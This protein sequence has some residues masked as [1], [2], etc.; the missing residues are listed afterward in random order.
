MHVSQ[1]LLGSLVR[2]GFTLASVI[3]K[4]D[5]LPTG[6]SRDE[7]LT[8][9]IAKDELSMKVRIHMVHQ[10][11]D[12]FHDL[13]MK[14]ATPG[15][16]LYGSHISQEVIN[17]MISPKDQ[18]KS[19]VLEWLNAEGLTASLSPRSDSVILEAS[20]SRIEKLLDTKYEVFGE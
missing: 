12:K 5:T 16:E 14:I 17:D 10:D 3:E 7:V 9:Q 19:L 11:I 8:G 20:I 1:L 15:H 2:A 6:W 4:L 13:A 18:S